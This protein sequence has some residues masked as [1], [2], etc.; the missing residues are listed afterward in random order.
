LLVAAQCVC[1][2][3]SATALSISSEYHRKVMA[4]GDSCKVQGGPPHA[5]MPGR[6]AS[7]ISRIVVNIG[8]GPSPPV[9]YADTP[10]KR[11]ARLPV[12]SPPGTTVAEPF[13]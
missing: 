8:T 6:M 7:E 4:K 12:A 5:V 3:Q 10:G 2:T 1:A 13:T 11:S 9:I